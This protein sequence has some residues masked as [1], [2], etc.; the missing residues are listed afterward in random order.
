M[1]VP[2]VIADVAELA[3]VSVA[4]VSL[5]LNG[6]GNISDATRSRVME[7]AQTLGY[8]PSA[9]ARNLRGN[10]ARVVGYAYDRHRSRFNPVLDNFLY[11][12]LRISESNGRNV[13]LFAH[14]SGTGVEAYRSLVKSRRVDGFIL[15]HTQQD[16]ER[17]VYLQANHIPFAAFGR[18]NSPMDAR[19]HWVDVDGEAGME[20]AVEHLL[21]CGYR[22]IAFVGWPQG[23][24]SGDG[25]YAG[26]VKAMQ[27][28]DLPLNFNWIRRTRNDIMSGYE[29]GQDLMSLPEPPEAIAA[30]SDIIA[31]GILRG[32]LEH[33]QRVAVTGFDDT[34]IA[35]FSHPP[36]TSLQQPVDEVARLLMQMLIA[37]FEKQ[38][39]PTLHHMLKPRLVVRASS[40]LAY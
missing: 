2:P 37:Q 22:R 4:T 12:I 19:A 33:G 20:A 31:V 7:A 40:T 27:A 21:A 26:Y 8:T 28:A 16:D 5:V 34:P 15:S 24:V 10:Q 25:R 9:H 11:E 18:S 17:F 13:L 39:V 1:S 30:V 29:A 23:S 38:S 14:E 3:G 32:M 6:K 35:E 36:L